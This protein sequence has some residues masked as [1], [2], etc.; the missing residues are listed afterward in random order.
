MYYNYACICIPLYVISLLVYVCTCTY[1]H[2]HTSSSNYVHLH[3]I[4]DW[5]CGTPSVVH[6]H[7]CTC[8]CVVHTLSVVHVHVCVWIPTPKNPDKPTDKGIIVHDQTRQQTKQHNTAQRK[9]TRDN[10]SF[11]QRTLY[12]LCVLC[13]LGQTLAV[14]EW[15]RCDKLLA[16]QPDVGPDKLTPASDH[17]CCRHCCIS[18]RGLL[19]THPTG[20]HSMSPGTYTCTW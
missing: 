2:V 19:R 10:F 5:L 11:F 4:T 14:C 9:N 18:G 20:S 15:G 6:V 1:I 8:M 16:G 7:T 12:Y 13:A 17:I 3:T